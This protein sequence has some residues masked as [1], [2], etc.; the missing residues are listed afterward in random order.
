[1]PTRPI[2]V[3]GIPFDEHSSYLRG[4]ASAPAKIREA[5]FNPSSNTWSESG[6]N[7]GGSGFLADY[8]DLALADATDAFAEIESRVSELI[9]GG[10]PLICLGGDHAITYP[11]IKA[12]H[13]L[14][15]DITILHFDA[16]PD[17]YDE[18]DGD[19]LSH[20]SPFARIMESK[21]AAR[22]I[23]VGIRCL[24]KVQKS[25]VDRFNV[26]TYEMKDYDDAWQF[27]FD[28]PLYISF[29]IDVLDPACA[30]GV[31]H[32]EPG[33]LTTRQAISLIQKIEASR[34]LGADIVELNPLRDLNG[35]TAMVAAKIMKEIA[36]KID[37]TRPQR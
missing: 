37:S 5:L 24:N 35:V 15:S 32:H 18:L 7:I 6:V 31:S 26:T 20:A 10:A 8:G 21:L 9:R 16:H 27:T 34:I 19:R 3:V 17:L 4:P 25:Q 30:P 13:R 28:S 36:A 22:L 14:H 23:Q 12:F 33:G 2:S 1:M 29:D 11:I